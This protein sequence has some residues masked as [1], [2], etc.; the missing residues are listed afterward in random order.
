M[1]YDLVLSDS[2]LEAMA[3][4]SEQGNEHL[5]PIKGG[6]FLRQLSDY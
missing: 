5:N 3:W 2:E 1:R 4:A 6:E